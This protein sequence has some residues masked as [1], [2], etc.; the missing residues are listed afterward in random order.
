MEVT[1][2]TIGQLKESVEMEQGTALNEKWQF[3]H[4]MLFAMFLVLG[5]PGRFR[6]N[7]NSKSCSKL[8]KSEHTAKKKEAI[9][10]LHEY[11]G[12]FKF[13]FSGQRVLQSQGLCLNPGWTI[14][15]LF[16]I[17]QDNPAHF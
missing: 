4:L 14:Y 10:K 15:K 13:S 11:K 16:G 3:Q 2:K 8:L 12:C 5:K 9:G 6:A 7:L 1:G 17:R